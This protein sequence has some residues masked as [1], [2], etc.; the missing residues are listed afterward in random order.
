MVNVSQLQFRYKKKNVF[1]NLN[2]TLQGGHIYGLLG[3]NGSGK[4]TLLR[5]LYGLLYPTSGQVNVLGNVPGIREPKFLQ[6]VFMVPEEFYLPDV[7]MEEL[8]HYH[9]Q[10]Y[11]QFSLSQFQNYLRE[12]EVPSDNSLQQMSYGQKKKVLI[13][14]G[15]ASNTPLL[16]MDEPTNGLDIISK[17]QFRKIMSGLVNHD[18][19]MIISTHQLKDLEN[20]ID[21]IVIIDEAKIL[22]NESLERIAQKLCFKIVTDT[23]SVNTALFTEPSIT[24]VAVVYANT[25]N[26]ETKVDLELLYKTVMANPAV[27]NNLFNS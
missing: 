22:F 7:K 11:P 8:I 9:A 10:F 1:D 18:K 14:L 6:Q 15:L 24:G 26:E 20:L 3:K 21:S 17:S 5:S 23:S 27:L 2:L 4:S 13:S 12:F 16:L 19:C 25:Q